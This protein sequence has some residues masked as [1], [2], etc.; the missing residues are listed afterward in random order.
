MKQSLDAIIIGAGQSGLAMAY[1]LKKKQRN[2]LIIDADSEV[3]ESWLKRW[4]S[5]K[6]FTSSE[7]NNLPGFS[8]PLEKGCYPN[9]YEV[10]NYLKAYA[11]RYEFNIEFN[12]RVRSVYKNEE[13]FEVV[14]D[15]SLFFAKEVF[16]ATGPFH[17][18]FTPP[19]A[20][21]ISSTV[22]QLH[23]K[24]YLNVGQLK[25]GDVCVVGAGDSG[26]QIAKEIAQDS[27]RKVYMSTSQQSFP[28]LPQE[29]LGKTLWWWLE[30]TG[31]LSL[32]VTSSLGRF[33]SAKMQP[34]IGTD[35]KALFR[36]KNV[37]KVGLSTGFFNNN[38]HFEGG[39]TASVAN[40]IWAT[41]YRPDFSMFQFDGLLNEKGYP[42]NTRGISSVDNLYF[43]GLPWMHTRGSATLG[44]VKKDAEYLYSCLEDLP[45]VASYGVQ[46]V[47]KEEESLVLEMA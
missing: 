37:E 30:K 44:G 8:F 11:A 7:H 42:E 1:Y 26:V 23:S 32:K 39:T 6:L 3:G 20:A 29:F 33:L 38:L 10:A 17:K 47:L 36:Q 28:T 15:N 25:E 2:F 22:N 35:V 14:T 27:N 4:D 45:E 46:D 18:P 12:Q 19:F 41:G 24:A 43:I 34:I 40:I 13:G 21:E 5:L 31:L 9:K 16:V